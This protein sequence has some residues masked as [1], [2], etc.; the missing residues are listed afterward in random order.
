MIDLEFSYKIL[1]IFA[2]IP[3]VILGTAVFLIESTYQNMQER[4]LEEIS[5]SVIFQKQKI[6]SDFDLF[7]NAVEEYPALP[8]WKNLS[9]TAEIN[10]TFGGIPENE[11]KSKRIAARFLISDFG[12]QSFGLT[13]LDGRMYLLEPFE[14]QQNLSKMNF[15]DREWFQGV[16]KNQKTYVSNVFISDATSH[17]IIVISTP[18]FSEDGKI[19]GMW[20]GSLDIEYL[21]EFLESVKKKNSSILLVDENMVTI[22]DTRDFSAHEMIQDEKI[23]KILEKGSESSAI[24]KQNEDYFFVSNIKIGNKNWDLVTEISEKNLIP[25]LLIQKNNNYVLITLMG[26]FIVASEYLLFKFLRKN[27]QLN[28]DIKENRK[29]LLKQERLAAIGELASRVSHDIRNPLSNIR[30]SVKLIENQPNTKI[31]DNSIKEK[32]Q[33]INKNINR[34]EHQIDDVLEYVKTKRLIRERISLDTCFEESIKLLH[35]PENI[36]INNDKTSLKIFVDPIQIHVVCNNILINAIQAIGKQNG[37]I[38]IRASE[39]LGHTVIEIENSG[40][41]IPTEVLPQIFDPLVTTKEIG[42]GLG[43]ASCKRIIEN[44]GGT[45]SVKNNPTT[46]IIKLPKS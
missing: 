17:P 31:N 3:F 23:I 38:T 33:I 9:H 4:E 42:T 29:I 15:S 2:I 26:I 41:P 46:F 43:L 20:G 28:S 40:P 25:Q 19:I 34:I 36:K 18:V 45:I 16:L 11:E 8:E 35:V 13:L 12:F 24:F 37:K 30:M 5:D 22:A 39:E 10:E 21:T 14:H 32:F 27:F 6:V 44:H 7:F 1:V